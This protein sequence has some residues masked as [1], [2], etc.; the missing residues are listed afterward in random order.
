[1]KN[2]IEFINEKLVLGKKRTIR[3]ID[4][5]FYHEALEDGYKTSFNNINLNYS[6]DNCKTWNELESQTW[7]PKINKGERIYFK[8]E[9][10]KAKRDYGIGQFESVKKFNI[11]GNIMSLIYGDDFKDQTKL[12]DIHQFCRLFQYNEFLISAEQL[13]LPATELTEYCYEYMFKSCNGLVT[14][15]E[16]PETTLTYMCYYS[17]FDGCHNLTKAP[18][19]P[20]TTLAS[21]CSHFMFKFCTSLTTA[22]ELPATKL[23]NN[24]YALMFDWCESLVIAPELPAPKLTK[25]CYMNMFGGCIKLKKITML[26]TDISA[27]EC[28]EEWVETVADTGTITISKGFKLPIGNKG[29]PK[30]WTV[31]EI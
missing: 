5:Y 8:G 24:C 13:I 2:L 16:L 29:I 10:M 11:G 19:L 21:F 12:L 18:E 25:R 14:A 3:N 15:P 7:T 27:E 31:K 30:G 6:I 22:P 17:M 28:L 26:A 9:N 20:A 23:A 1:M 4:V